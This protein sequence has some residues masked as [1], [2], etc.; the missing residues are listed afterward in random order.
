MKGTLNKSTVER[1]LLAA[2]QVA[3]ATQSGKLL[4]KEILEK[5][6]LLFER[7]AIR[8]QNNPANFERWARLTIE[9]AKALAPYQSPQFA[10]LE[11]PSPPPSLEGEPPRRRISLRVFEGGRP[12]HDDADDDHYRPHTS[13]RDAS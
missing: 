3:E 2:R 6:M 8:A 1:S 5:Y 7:R 12:V 4:A 10:R 13:E 9:T 11:A